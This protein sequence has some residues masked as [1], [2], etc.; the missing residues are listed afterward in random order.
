MLA[1]LHQRRHHRAV[2]EALEEEQVRVFGHLAQLLQVVA[3]VHE[4]A[5]NSD[6]ALF[7]NTARTFHHREGQRHCRLSRQGCKSGKEPAGRMTGVA[8]PR[9]DQY[10]G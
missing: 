8:I 10:S 1:H 9:L 5:W 7:H 2:Q 4:G 3:Y 6:Q